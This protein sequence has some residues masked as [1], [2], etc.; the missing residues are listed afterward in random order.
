MSFGLIELISPVKGT[1]S[2]TYKGLRLPSIELKP[3]ILT[4]APAPGLPLVLVTATPAD[5]PIN[6]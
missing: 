3:L 1:P 2:T 4:V 5:S 6:A